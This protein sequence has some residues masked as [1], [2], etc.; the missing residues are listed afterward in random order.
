M[1]GQLTWENDFHMAC[2][3]KQDERRSRCRD[4]ECTYPT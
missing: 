1:I 4:I 3:C 2:F